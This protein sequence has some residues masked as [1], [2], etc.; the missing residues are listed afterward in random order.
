MSFTFRPAKRENIPLIIGLIGGTGSGKTYS[1]LE[2]ATG[3]AKG[4]RFAVI[5]TEA[6]RAKHYADSFEFDH[7]DLKPPFRPDAYL[8]AITSAEDAGYPVI[9]VDSMSHEHA[10]EGGLLDWHEE[11][12]AKANYRDSAKMTCWIKPKMA[13]KSMV[14]RLLQLRSHLILCFRAEEKTK[15]TRDPETKK[16]LIEP[17]G[18]QPICAKGLEFEMMASFLLSHEAP[19]M[20][21]T[22]LKLPKH[23]MPFFP[24][25]HHIGRKAG[26]AIEEWAKGAS[27][28]ANE[29]DRV[30]D[31]IKSFEEN[32]S[33]LRMAIDMSYDLNVLKLVEPAIR[34]LPDITR[35]ELGDLYNKR[36]K[37]LSD[38]RK[39]ASGVA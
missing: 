28:A 6:G 9:V 22:P 12:F 4:K 35:K 7:G 18:W 37:E 21:N 29:K 11:E 8:E 33:K 34:N 32:I 31:G 39:P 15:V 13:H 10:G 5:D 30:D 19:G 27:E 17:A 25:G 14:Q 3:I 36:R 2:L 24:K 23:M 1:A 38:I 16:M 26:A 20:P